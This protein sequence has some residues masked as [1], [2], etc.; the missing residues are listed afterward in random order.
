[1]ANDSLLELSGRANGGLQL[2]GFL[3]STL[4]FL[5]LGWPHTAL[6]GA[7]RLVLVEANLLKVLAASF[8]A[9]LSTILWC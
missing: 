6:D 4:V 9:C 2:D 3:G 8:A 5:N 1:L 7:G